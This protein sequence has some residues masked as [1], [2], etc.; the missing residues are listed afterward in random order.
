MGVAGFEYPAHAAVPQGTQDFVTRNG[1]AGRRGPIAR[2]GRRCRNLMFFRSGSHQHRAAADRE[3]HT[4]DAL[5]QGL[6]F[7]I[8]G[9]EQIVAFQGVY[10][11][12][13]RILYLQAGDCLQTMLTVDEMIGHTSHVL[14]EQLTSEEVL[15][16]DGI[17]TEDHV[18][19][20]SD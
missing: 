8:L 12:Q 16:P 15:Q 4:T 11:V 10:G 17:G 20:S 13:E 18:K 9:P 2:E 6:D 19:T 5:D 1:G 14:V 7:R 3:A